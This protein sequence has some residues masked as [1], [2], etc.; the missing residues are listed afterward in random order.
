MLRY[1]TNLVRNGHPPLVDLE[2]DTT[3]RG[4]ALDGGLEAI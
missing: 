2:T 1:C 3:R 4:N